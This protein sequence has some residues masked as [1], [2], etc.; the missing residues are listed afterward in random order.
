MSVWVPG[1][2]TSV[3]RPALLP[4]QPLVQWVSGPFY[5]GIKWSKRE[6]NHSPPFSAATKEAIPLLHYLIKH[7]G[8]LIFLLTVVEVCG[9]KRP[10][11][12]LRYCPYICLFHGVLCTSERLL[13]QRLSCR[14]WPY[15]HLELR[16]PDLPRLLIFNVSIISCPIL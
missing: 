7:R 4:S 10:W 12:V 14:V 1:E 2:E 5:L 9:R 3:S 16:V 6:T 13:F 8:N 15:F 11:P